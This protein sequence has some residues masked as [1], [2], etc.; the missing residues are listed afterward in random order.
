M[1]SAA[2]INNAA[3]PTLERL[4]VSEPKDV[5]AAA[6]AQT[7]FDTFAN[8]I[9]R[10]DVDRILGQLVDDAFWRDILSLTW[11]FRTFYGN[12]CIK[13]FLTDRL[14][15]SKLS[16]FQLD[17]SSAAV[18]KPYPDVS[19][20]QAFFTFSTA[21]GTA[22]GILRL[23]PVPGDGWKAHT[24]FTSLEG[25]H[26]CPELTGPLREQEPKHGTWPE[27]RKRESECEGPDQQ[28]AVLIVGGGQSGLE[29]AARLKYLGVKTLII[30]REARIGHLWR[31]RYEALC[32][33]DT[34][35]TSENFLC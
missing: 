5:N 17:A 21:V 10:G 11:D 15:I 4:K 23:V 32:L 31:K 26:G 27:Q 34:V 9:Q 22:S 29:L 1:N 25:L 3:L 7:W 20:I 6:V 8:H 35:C 12:D 28:P 2:D 30:E 24:I 19:W 14:A 13:K 33:H 16:A 18:Q